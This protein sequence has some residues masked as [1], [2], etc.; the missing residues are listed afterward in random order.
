MTNVLEF[1]I[2]SFGIETAIEYSE[3][4]FINEINGCGYDD[5]AF[6]ITLTPM[7]EDDFG[8]KG[9]WVFMFYHPVEDM[10]CIVSDKE[11]CLK[12]Y[13]IEQALKVM[14]KLHEFDEICF[15]LERNIIDKL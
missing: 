7:L 2:R 13:T 1:P 8:D 14:E 4:E 11:G 3:E 12:Q 15:S 6:K 10:L 5:S 9:G